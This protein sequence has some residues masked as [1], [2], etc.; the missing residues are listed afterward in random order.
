MAYYLNSKGLIPMLIGSNEYEVHPIDVID[1]ETRVNGEVDPNFTSFFELDRLTI[2]YLDKFNTNK[3]TQ[4]ELKQQLENNPERAQELIRLVV[5]G[6]ISGANFRRLVDEFEIENTVFKPNVSMIEQ[7]LDSFQLVNGTLSGFV[8]YKKTPVYD[9]NFDGIELKGVIQVYDE[10][11]VVVNLTD[12]NVFFSANQ[13]Q[14]SYTVL[15]NLGNFKNISVES[16]LFYDYPNNPQPMAFNKKIE[17]TDVIQQPTPAP[18][19]EPTPAPEPEPTP[20]PEPEPT[21]CVNVYNVRESGEVYSTNY[22][23][24]SGAKVDELQ[25]EFLVVSCEAQYLPTEKQVQDFYGF[26]PIPPQDNTTVNTTMVSQ[27]I[28]SFDLKDGRIRGEILYIANQSFNPYYYNKNIISV[29]QIKSKGGSVITLKENN[30]NF[31]ETERDERIQIDESVA[32]FKEV[33]IEFFVFDGSLLTTALPVPFTEAKQIQIIQEDVSTCPQGFHKDFSGKC[34]ADD[35]VGEV[36]R[37]KLIDTLKGF[38][39]GTVALSLLARKY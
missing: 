29:V 24:I 35:P 22:A 38:L 34:V 13:N 2:V 20:A 5:N 18:E 33:I 11:G 7:S 31:T 21:Y 15:R 23:S 28:G 1:F 10:D 14:T 32:N 6:E 19:P 30:L 36:P 27:S 25:K 37:D 17:L 3:P 4:P 9:P 26:T 12:H 8:I 16:F 39:F